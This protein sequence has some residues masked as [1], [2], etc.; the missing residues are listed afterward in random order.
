[1]RRGAIEFVL[2]GE[3]PVRRTRISQLLSTRRLVNKC[4]LLN[5]ESSI[6]TSPW[7]KDRSSGKPAQSE[8]LARNAAVHSRGPDNR[9][10]PSAKKPIAELQN[11]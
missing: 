7:E 4:L 1:M 2:E 9:A 8:D 3:L 11:P 10:H 6:S 5:L